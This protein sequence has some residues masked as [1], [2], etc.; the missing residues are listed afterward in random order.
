M[1]TIAGQQ[2]LDA[3]RGRR[4]RAAPPA[5]RIA[6]SFVPRIEG[7]ARAQV[8]IR[9]EAMRHA[10]GWLRR[11]AVLDVFDQITEEEHQ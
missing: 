1:P 3:I 4:D 5:Y 2:L 7:E 6:E 9:I 11:Q 8:R 10:A